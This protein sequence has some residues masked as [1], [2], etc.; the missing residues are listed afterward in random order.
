[1]I[2]KSASFHVWL[3]TPRGSTG[4]SAVLVLF[5]S[6]GVQVSSSISATLFSTYGPIPVSCLRMVLA[7]IVLLVAVRPRLRGR[8]LRQW[9]AIVMYGVA[10]AAMNITLYLALERIP[11]GIAVTLEFLGPCAVALA[12]S[13]KLREAACALLALTGVGLI[14]L[15][16]GSYFDALGYLFALMDAACFG[17]YTIFAAKVGK[18]GTGLDGLALSVTVAALLTLPVSIIHAPHVSGTHWWLLALSA[19]LGVVLPYGVDTIAG[20]LTSARVVG[21]LF[22]IDPA[23]G[24]LIG[25]L[26]LG[27]TI[28]ITAIAGILIVSLSGALLVW[29]AGHAN[30][31]TVTE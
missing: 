30:Q 23:M 15:G 12:A 1:M 28:T 4:T 24:A 3:H 25:A 27:Q 20:R 13:R 9:M 19:L 26:L 10:M 8:D 22:A 6:A 18:T 16:P 7:A 11:L 14:S 29:A 31:T 5:G 2:S 17:L 21:T